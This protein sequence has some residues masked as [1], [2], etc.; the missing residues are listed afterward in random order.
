MHFDGLDQTP[1]GGVLLAVLFNVLCQESSLVHVKGALPWV[2]FLERVLLWLRFDLLLAQK[3]ELWLR[4]ACQFQKLLSAVLLRLA[5]HQD[6]SQIMCCELTASLGNSAVEFLVWNFIV[7]GHSAQL[8]LEAACEI[9]LGVVV[10]GA[11]G[12]LGVLRSRSSACM[13]SFDDASVISSALLTPPRCP[14]SES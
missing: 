11:L 6:R 7:L 4:C 10:E 13:L 1:R 12:E 9:K 2:A 5:F 3:P 14:S 8:L